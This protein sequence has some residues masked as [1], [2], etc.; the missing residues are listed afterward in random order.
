MTL[1]SNAVVALAAVVAGLSGAAGAE[2]QAGTGA[3]SG[4]AEAPD[5][6]GT[7]PSLVLHY[8][9]AAGNGEF[10]VNRAENGAAPLVVG[11]ITI[12][13]TVSGTAGAIHGAKWTPDGRLPGRP[14]LYFDGQGRAHVACGNAPAINNLHKKTLCVRFRVTG[15]GWSGNGNIL[16]K[17]GT[18]AGPAYSPGWRLKITTPDAQGRFRVVYTHCY[19]EHDGSWACAKDLESGQWRHVAITHDANQPSALP[20]FYIDGEPSGAYVNQGPRGALLD[21]SGA[22]LTIGRMTASNYWAFEGYIDEIAVYNRILSHEEIRE[23]WRAP[24]VAPPQDAGKNAP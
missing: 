5:R 2:R 24:G 9:F 3:A 11:G 18:V 12:E 8:T 19:A 15:K 20:C 10:L 13:P 1:R 6:R 4:R 21:D 22:R 16:S 14:C 17:T 23:L 7:D